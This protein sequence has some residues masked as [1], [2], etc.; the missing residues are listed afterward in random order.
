MIKLTLMVG[1]PLFKKVIKAVNKGRKDTRDYRKDAAK[2]SSKEV[3]TLNQAQERV[4][5]AKTVRDVS[6]KV[7]KMKKLPK[8]ARDSFGKAFEGVLNKRIKTRN[9]LMD[10]KYLKPKKNKIGGYIKAKKGLFI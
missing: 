5:T 8:E 9:I 3:R 1:K 4:E 10:P 6:Q 7:L 2:K